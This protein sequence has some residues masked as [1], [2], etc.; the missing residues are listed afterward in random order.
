MLCPDLTI[1]WNFNNSCGRFL[2][3]IP[4][5]LYTVSRLS[6]VCLVLVAAAMNSAH[7][8]KV[9]YRDSPPPPTPT[10]ARTP[11]TCRDIAREWCGHWMGKWSKVFAC[12]YGRIC[13]YNTDVELPPQQ[14][15]SPFRWNYNRPGSEGAFRRRNGMMECAA[16]LLASHSL[17]RTIYEES[18]WIEGGISKARLSSSAVDT[19]ARNQVALIWMDFNLYYSIFQCT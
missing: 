14:L 4:Q 16:V 3:A 13:M 7:E 6:A 19:L 18:I 17:A 2:T 1:N 11:T 15:S 5:S 8:S 10:I 12:A 9:Y